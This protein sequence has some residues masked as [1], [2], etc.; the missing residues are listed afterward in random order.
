MDGKTRTISDSVENDRMSRV[1]RLLMQTIGR[2]ESQD[3]Q[4]KVLKNKL[5]LT[6]NTNRFARWVKSILGVKNNHILVQL[7]SIKKN[8][9]L[10]VK[11]LK[12]VSSV[13]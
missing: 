3:E 8:E 7:H 9:P 4:L 10:S 12:I 6:E 11:N 13:R 2:L 1:E 5:D